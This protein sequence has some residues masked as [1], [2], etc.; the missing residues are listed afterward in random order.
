MTYQGLGGRVYWFV[1]EKLDRKYTYPYVPRFS[2]P[3]AV[4]NCERLGSVW[5][6]NSVHFRD[7]WRHRETFAMTALEEAVLRPWSDGRIVCIGDSI[8]KVHTPT[9]PS[10]ISALS[11]GEGSVA[12]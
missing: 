11:M 5:L 2:D 8:H 9:T 7:V 1:V 12:D 6:R 3:D 4:R 10:Y